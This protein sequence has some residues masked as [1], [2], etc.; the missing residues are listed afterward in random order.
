MQHQIRISKPEYR[1]D[2][3]NNFRAN[4]VVCT[5]QFLSDALFRIS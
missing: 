1:L 5:Y 4:V 2:Y 3:F